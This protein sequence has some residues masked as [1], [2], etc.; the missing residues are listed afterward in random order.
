MTLIEQATH[1]PISSCTAWGFSY[2]LAYAWGGGLL[3]RLF[4]ISRRVE[5]GP[6]KPPTGW[7]SILC[8]T[9][10]RVELTSYTPT[11]FSLHGM[12]PSGVRTF[13][14]INSEIKRPS[15]ARP[16]CREDREKGG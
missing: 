14:F 7:L 1:P 12:L 11:R 13:L 15:P 10:R 5:Y 16:S 8:D 4:T 9:L 2:P 3:P 6:K